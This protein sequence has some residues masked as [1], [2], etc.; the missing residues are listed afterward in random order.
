M[1]R[2]KPSDVAALDPQTSEEVLD[3]L[4]DEC[5][6]GDFVTL[7]TAEA[8][9][10]R[11]RTPEALRT[12]LSRPELR[13]E[14]IDALAQAITSMQITMMVRRYHDGPHGAGV[15]M[16][17][18]R[19]SRLRRRFNEIHHEQSAR[20]GRDAERLRHA[21][22]WAT[23]RLKEAYPAEFA[24]A[25]AAAKASLGGDPPPHL[26]SPSQDVALRDWVMQ[27]GYP[28]PALDDE[29][30][31]VLL[32]APEGFRNAVADEVKDPGLET[33]FAH[34]L[35]IE[36]WIEA[37]AHLEEHTCDLLGVAR[38]G[39]GQFSDAELV[40]AEGTPESDAL[41][42]INRFRFLGSLFARQAEARRELRSIYGTMNEWAKQQRHDP[43]LAQARAEL[44]AAHRQEFDDLVAGF[45]EA[46][47]SADAVRAGAGKPPM[48]RRVLPQTAAQILNAA[49]GQGW[50]VDLYT[51]QVPGGVA[52]R[53]YP[54]RVVVEARRGAGP[55]PAVGAVFRYH[56][57]W[58][59]VRVH[60]LMRS[61]HTAQ[62]TGLET[63][64]R[65]VSFPGVAD[66]IALLVMSDDEIAS[67]VCT[68][69]GRNSTNAT[70]ARRS[71]E[72]PTHSD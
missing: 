72:L 14:R 48:K 57:S 55:F 60:A 43:A 1:P 31:S 69:S 67:A 44:V 65:W 36:A 59:L 54:T 6:W 18:Q 29:Q 53:R 3:E 8:W 26:P 62:G 46:A 7:V 70:A 68:R 40:I 47:I 32:M 12:V 30:R 2:L 5:T 25:V 33:I 11:P 42:R 22:G 66:V 9:Y 10:P 17:R 58:D 23:K 56:G 34:P 16:A 27:Y 28:F 13:A 19:L 49:V 41:L 50:E 63:L 64:Q 15:D 4:L 35:L 38:R 24:A 51:P 61:E 52:H 71:R 39:S 20:P 45:D 37:L 21:R